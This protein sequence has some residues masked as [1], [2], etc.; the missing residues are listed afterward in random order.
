[1][2]G[3]QDRGRV[4]RASAKAGSKPSTTV[5]DLD[6]HF[7]VQIGAIRRDISCESP[8]GG[9]ILAYSAEAEWS[10][11][12]LPDEAA[13]DLVRI[14]SRLAARDAARPNGNGASGGTNGDARKKAARQPRRVP[15][16]QSRRK[17]GEL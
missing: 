8:P 6:R 2:A 4:R 13:D 1:V 16:K 10:P 5:A 11:S 15:T 7:D 17:R 3:K 9:E 14:L 12:P